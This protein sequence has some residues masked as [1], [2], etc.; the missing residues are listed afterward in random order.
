MTAPIRVGAA[1]LDEDTIFTDTSFECAAWYRKVMVR[2]GEFPIVTDPDSY[3]GNRRIVLVG[4]IEED[5]F[6]SLNHG[7][8]IG[9]DYDRL[10]NYGKLADLSLNTYDYQLTDG[11]TFAGS[12]RISLD[13]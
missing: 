5:Y 1:T 8:P 7:M 11:G 13:A 10:C 2:A 3:S 6:Q 12:L 9:H 4:T